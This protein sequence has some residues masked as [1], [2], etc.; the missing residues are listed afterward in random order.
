MLTAAVDLDPGLRR[1]CGYLNDDA[2]ACQPTPQLAAGLFQWPA[3]VRPGPE[4]MLVRWGLA[5]PVDGVAAPWSGTAPWAADPYIVCWMLE[6]HG[7]DPVLGDGVR[8]TA[9]EDTPDTC[10]YSELLAEMKAFA[11]ALQGQRRLP[12]G[13]G[14]A[15][16]IDLLGPE[17]SG[18][19]TLAAQLS[20]ELGAGLVVADAGLLLGPDVAPHLAAERA[21]H[22][23]RLARLH[24][25]VLYW[26]D[27]GAAN[28]RAWAS[29]HGSVDLTL[30]GSTAARI[31]PTRTEVSRCSFQLPL[32]SRVQRVALWTNLADGPVPDPVSDWMLTPGEIAAAARVTPAGPQAVVEACRRELAQGPGGLIAPLARPYTWDDLVLAPQTRCHLEELQNQARLR[33]PV[34]EDWGFERR[35]PGRRAPARPWPPRWSPTPWPWSCTAWTLQAS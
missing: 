33:W 3:H 35:F 25:A 6:S 2:T 5:R 18:K 10:L 16:E 15:V 20:A 30:F 4:S 12:K 32:L 29:V 26:H 13:G 8:L 9:A 22:A 19:R 14:P 7:R 28:P 24:G 31:R 34:Y 17:G 11:E 23:A 21:L 27:A 1:V